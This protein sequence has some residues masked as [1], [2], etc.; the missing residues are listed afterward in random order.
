MPRPTDQLTQ[1]TPL[2][3]PD[4]TRLDQLCR[5]PR[6]RRQQPRRHRRH[7]H[8][9]AVT[10]LQA[11]RTGASVDRHADEALLPETMCRSALSRTRAVDQNP[12]LLHEPAPVRTI[13]Q[14][15]RRWLADPAIVARFEIK[16]YRRT[17]A[18]CWYYIG[19]IS[20]TGHGNFRAASLP[21]RSRRGTV[22]AHLFAYQ[23]EFGRDK[24]PPEAASREQRPVRR[25][26][27]EV[28][29]CSLCW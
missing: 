15:W 10:A 14:L 29:S 2:D 1:Q 11:A 19:A 12:V 6:R 27:Y 9:D 18:Q 21:G 13:P 25:P 24:T 5:G 17:R 26:R 3:H 20:S 16:R 28:I 22:Q 7:L 23:L 4:Q 8:S